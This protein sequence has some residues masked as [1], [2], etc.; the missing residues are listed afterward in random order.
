MNAP[1][2]ASNLSSWLRTSSPS[3]NRTAARIRICELVSWRRY[4]RSSRRGNCPARDAA[5]AMVSTA[6][7]S[8][9]S[10]AAPARNPPLPLP[11][12]S[13]ESSTIEPNSA[14]EHETTTK[15]PNAVCVWCASF[16]TGITIPSA[17]AERIT[18]T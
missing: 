10:L 5:N 6:S 8:R 3:S 15:R 18:V 11:V 9:P 12:N 1:R 16:S 2:I 17:V 14:T 4:I 7:T 13:S